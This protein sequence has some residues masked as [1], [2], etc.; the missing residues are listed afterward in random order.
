MIRTTLL[1]SFLL[2]GSHAYEPDNIMGVVTISDYYPTNKKEFG[3]G[4]NTVTL[5]RTY[6]NPVEVSTEH[7][8][9]G[10]YIS[11]EFEIKLCKSR[12][13]FFSSMSGGVSTSGSYMGVEGSASVKFLTETTITS[14]DS[15]LIAS[16]EAVTNTEY[17]PATG[18]V[19]DAQKLLDDELYERF[20]ETYGTHYQRNIISG[21]KMMLIMKFTSNSRENKSEL[22]SKLGL[23]TGVFGAEAEFAAAMKSVKESSSMSVKS[24]ASGSNTE[25]PQ[26][27]VEACIQYAIDFAKSVLEYP[28][29]KKLQYT[30]LWTIPGTPQA[31]KQFIFGRQ[32]DTDKV[33]RISVGLLN[34]D[35]R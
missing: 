2:A 33:V 22:D 30:A 13:E 14:L 31:F 5:R 7:F 4:Y 28:A 9:G 1:L 34:V 35:N 23:S 3:T 8:L 32:S 6:T 12:E 11:C 26:P 18:Y 21:G 27:N 10:G 16:V 29:V 25:P 19:A 17:A 24:W 15:V 20:I